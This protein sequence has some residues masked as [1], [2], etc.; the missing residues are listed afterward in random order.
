MTPRAELTTARLTLRPLA[1]ADEAAVVEA[2][3]VLAVTGW[4]AVVPYPYAAADFQYF[5]TEVA[6]PGAAFTVCDTQG[7]AGIISVEDRT[8]GYWF[9]PH[10]HGLGYA[11]EAARAA[12]AD[13][14]AENPG[15]IA[16]GYFEGNERSANVL[17]KLGFVDAGREMKFCRA[18]NKDRPHVTM[19]LTRD[20][21]V[22]ALPTLARS[23]RLTYRT[24]QATDLDALHD[25]VSRPEVLRFLG[26]KWP[27]PADPAFTLTRSTPYVGDGFV[28]GIFR[29]GAH[30]GSVSVTDGELG[31]VIHPDHQGQGLASEAVERCLTRAFD[32]DGLDEVHAGVWADNL[33]SLGLLRKFG[34]QITG[35]DMGT[36][37]LRPA[38]SPGFTL[39]L[40]RADWL[41]RALIRTKRLSMRPMSSADAPLFHDLVTRPEVARM[42]FMFPTDWTLP[43]AVAF[44]DDWAWR[45][46]LRFRLALIHQGHWAGW[47]GV[48][49]AP[50]PEIFYALRPEF[51]GKGLAREGVAAFAAFLFA[52][53]APPA[54]TAGVF[55]DNSASARLLQ[56][57]GF[58]FNHEELHASRGR[59]APAPAQV[60]RLANPNQAD[61]T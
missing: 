43:Q 23:A 40:S 55:T 17:R 49:D 13:H 16:S 35:E 33:G 61:R 34:F 32:E 37:A 38:P 51:A 22:A 28:W 54:L 52:R 5:L 41:A 58:R 4:L 29:N 10:C 8:L 60:Y 18:L 56:A 6:L 57:C 21:F 50:E 31:Y 36:N 45:G 59:L 15:D 48:N 19:A 39:R 14:F 30:I 24:R 11:T 1:A 2:L 7:F 27:W 26:P 25:L 53:F 44:L 47:I 46:T 20:A 12:L 9:V 42:L 3:N